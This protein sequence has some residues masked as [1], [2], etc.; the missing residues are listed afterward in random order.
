MNKRRSK[1]PVK[2]EAGRADFSHLT[3]HDM[4]DRLR[5]EAEF[6]LPARKAAAGGDP[7][8]SVDT[9]ENRGAKPPRAK[10]PTRST[11]TPR[12]PQRSVTASEEKEQGLRDD[13]SVEP[14]QSQA[15]EKSPGPETSIE[16]A[17]PQEAAPSTP[18]SKGDGL[19]DRNPPEEKETVS[20]A[21]IEDVYPFT[22]TL[23][24]YVRRV[25]F[26]E[27]PVKS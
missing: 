25:K 18:S 21:N 2:A 20:G 6:E 3:S 27:I 14:G 19:G 17:N 10:S 24:T 26:S 12:R 13:S 9:A 23:L 8:A 22:G 1:R 4:A 11:R 5:G 16:D 7:G 15:K